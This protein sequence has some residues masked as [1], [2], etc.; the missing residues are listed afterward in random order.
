[1]SRAT[2]AEKFNTIVAPPPI[3]HLTH[4]RML[5]TGDRLVNSGD[6][7]SAIALSLGV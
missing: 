1:M 2:F 4:W 5:L 7:I 6:A 3:D